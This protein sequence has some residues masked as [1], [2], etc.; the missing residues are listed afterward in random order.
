MGDLGYSV[1]LMILGWD[2]PI[3][4]AWVWTKVPEASKKYPF[5]AS[6]IISCLF[7]IAISATTLVVCDRLFVR[8]RLGIPKDSVV[9]AHEDGRCPSGYR[10]MSTA[11]IATWKGAP[12]RFQTAKDIN[13]AIGVTTDGNWPYDHIKLCLRQ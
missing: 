3:G 11:L 10:D 13:L 2:I 5:A 7:A 4:L 8:D 1:L 9:L 12:E 6:T